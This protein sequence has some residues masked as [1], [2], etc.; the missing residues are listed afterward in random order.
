MNN[1][2][3]EL[4]DPDFQFSFKLLFLPFGNK[5]YILEAESHAAMCQWMKALRVASYDSMKLK[6]SDLQRQ[7]DEIKSK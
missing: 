2:V 5:S 1:F 3:I 6:V 4:A 7:L